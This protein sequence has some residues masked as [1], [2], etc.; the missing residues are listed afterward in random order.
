MHP[1]SPAPAPIRP[2]ALLAVL[3]LAIL[4][5][6]TA[7]GPAPELASEPQQTQYLAVPVQVIEA[8]FAA[9][10]DPE[11]LVMRTPVN[12]RYPFMAPLSH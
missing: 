10:D 8:P 2:T 12:G 5:L 9:P 4:T 1:A 11:P 3:A 6:S 7:T